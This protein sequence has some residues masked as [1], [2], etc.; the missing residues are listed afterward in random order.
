M[1]YKLFN[2]YQFLIKIKLK[3]SIIVMSKANKLVN[4]DLVYIKYINF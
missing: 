3:Y 1:F 4:N 2:N